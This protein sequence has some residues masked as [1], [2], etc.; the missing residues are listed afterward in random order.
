MTVTEK[1]EVPLTAG[2]PD[3]PPVPVFSVIPAGKAPATTDQVNGVVP[4]L[5]AS[6][7][8]TD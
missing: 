3:N 2:V 4:P 1:V 7:V 6:E 5:A 8:A